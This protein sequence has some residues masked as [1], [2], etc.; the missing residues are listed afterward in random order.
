M[1][2]QK[3]SSHTD[4]KNISSAQLYEMSCTVF[5]QN[6]LDKVKHISLLTSPLHKVSAIQVSRVVLK[7]VS[8]QNMNI[9]LIFLLN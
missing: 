4:L 5:L 9:Y 2:A 3:K 6:S 7:K 1:L 8:L